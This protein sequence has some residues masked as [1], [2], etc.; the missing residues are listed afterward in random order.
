VLT[1]KLPNQGF[2]VVMLK[3][4]LL[5]FH[6]HQHD[7]INC[8]GIYVSQMNNDMEHLSKLSSNLFSFVPYRIV[9]NRSNTMGASREAVHPRFGFVLLNL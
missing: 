1:R 5:K 9:C 7:M 2:L 6:G 4:S 8:Y 3:A